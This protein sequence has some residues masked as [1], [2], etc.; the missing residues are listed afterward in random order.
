ML[1]KIKLDSLDVVKHSLTTFEFKEV[2][3]LKGCSDLQYSEGIGLITITG[4][5]ESMFNALY[6]LSKHCDIEIM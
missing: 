1:I 4:S 6:M 5:R 2:E 3:K